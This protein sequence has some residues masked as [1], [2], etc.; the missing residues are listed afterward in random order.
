MCMRLTRLFCGNTLMRYK[1]MPCSQPCIGLSRFQQVSGAVRLNGAS[2][3][4][5]LRKLT[6]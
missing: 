6:L 2:Q 4:G 5:P 1:R 3:C